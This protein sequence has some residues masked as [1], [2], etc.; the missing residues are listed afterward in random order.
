[1][2]RAEHYLDG[3]CHDGD[4]AGR[5]I[6]LDLLWR[7]HRPGH[8]LDLSLRIGS[9]EAKM[10]PRDGGAKEDRFLRSDRAGSGF[11]HLWRTA[12]HRQAERR[13]LDP[14][15]TKEMDRQRDLGRP[16]NHLGTRR[17]RRSGQRL[18]RRESIAWISRREDP[19]QDGASRRSE[20][21][22]YADK[23]QGRRVKPAR[24]R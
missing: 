14:E 5:R 11:G 2:P 3:L 1:M 21:T 10:A 18:C 6:D 9:T 4:G 20:R 17:R 13:H 8:G 16:D 23:L 12:H 24:Q 15:R 7:P 19:T 22:H